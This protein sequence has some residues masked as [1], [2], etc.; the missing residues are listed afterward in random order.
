MLEL[1]MHIL[2]IVQNSLRAQARRVEVRILEDLERD[3]L[4]I[5][6]L[7]DGRGMPPDILKRVIDPFYTTRPARVAGLGIPFLKEAAERC[8]GGLEVQSQEGKGTRI[9]A[10]FQLDHF[11]RAPLGDLGETMAILIT[12]NPGVDFFYEHRVDG[13]VYRLDTAE[14]RA[15][16]GT[17]G[18]EDPSVFSLIQADIREGLKK[19]GASTFPKIA[20]ILRGPQSP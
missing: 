20:G 18:L 19:I 11:D 13:R 4:R 16:L 15:V 2:D 9:V 17:V 12:G 6:V 1:S 3:L 5:E 7:D 14:M 10:T 8:G